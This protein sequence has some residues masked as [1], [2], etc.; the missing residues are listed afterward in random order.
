MPGKVVETNSGR[1]KTDNKE[2]FINGK[3]IV[4]LD[5]GRKILC[6]VENIKTIGYWD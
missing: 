6:S 3:I 5:S 1:G 2:P 4:V